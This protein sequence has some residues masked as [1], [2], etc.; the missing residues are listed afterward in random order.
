MGD[1]CVIGTKSALSNGIAV[2]SPSEYLLAACGDPPAV[3]M[4]QSWMPHT[5]PPSQWRR[6]SQLPMSSYS[7]TD[8]S[9][10]VLSITQDA[11][12]RR[13]A[14]QAASVLESDDTNEASES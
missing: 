8:I 9:L 10:G 4:S 12:A 14:S 7:S 11:A 2:R 6:S 13:S 1:G 5:Q 3:C